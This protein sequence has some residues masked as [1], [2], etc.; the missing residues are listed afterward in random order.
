M[1]TEESLDDFLEIVCQKK[2][3]LQIL[4]DDGIDLGRL[5]LLRIRFG[6]ESSVSV[7][8]WK[9]LCDKGVYLGLSWSHEFRCYS[10]CFFFSIF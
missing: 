10:S 5:S 2:V 6:F 7:T 8:D 3:R 9:N 4:L 1:C